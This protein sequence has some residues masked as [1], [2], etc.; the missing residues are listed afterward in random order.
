MLGF[1]E[2]QKGQFVFTRT[3]YMSYSKVDTQIN[4]T[5]RF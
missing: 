4:D 1:K 5:K 2:N 3:N